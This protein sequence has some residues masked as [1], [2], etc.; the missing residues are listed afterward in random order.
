VLSRVSEKASET[1]ATI[2]CTGDFI[3]FV[4]L[5]NLERIAQFTE[6]NDCFMAAGNHEFSLYV[7]EAKEDADYRNQSLDK[8]QAVFKNDIRCSSRIIGGVNFVALD[9][10]YYL[11]EEEQ[12]TFLQNE[13]KKGLPIILLMHTPLYEKNLYDRMLTIHPCAY[14]MDVPEE[15]MQHYPADRYEQQKADEVTHKTVEYIRT[16]PLIRAAI[17]GHIHFNYE[18][19]AMERIPQYTTS[20]TD[21]RLFEIT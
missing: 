9:N 10:G 6:K 3:D 12:L 4:S 2:I 18:G 20:C 21:I 1:G 14:L 7:G 17:C 15:F 5:A 13:V 8:V 11:F 16:Q 19:M